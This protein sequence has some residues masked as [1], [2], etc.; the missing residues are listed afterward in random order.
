MRGGMGWVGW[1]EV[2]KTAGGCVC[3]LANRETASESSREWAGWVW[4]A[5]IV[6]EAGRGGGDVVG[7]VERMHILGL[8]PSLHK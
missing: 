6:G 7:S 3:R 2:V 8:L 4:V 1:W 5:V